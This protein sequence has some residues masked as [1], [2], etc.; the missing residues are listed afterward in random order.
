MRTKQGGGIFPDLTSVMIRDGL[1]HDFAG[2]TII[3]TI[4]R[5]Q[6]E[7]VASELKSEFKLDYVHSQQI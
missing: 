7:D 4:T 6:A 5:K 1:T 3:Y 2:S